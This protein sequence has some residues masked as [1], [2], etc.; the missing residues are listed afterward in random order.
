S[1]DDFTADWHETLTVCAICRGLSHRAALARLLYAGPWLADPKKGQAVNDKLFR[2]GAAVVLANSAVNLPHG[3]AHVGE[4]AYLPPLANAFVT[5]VIVLAPF[6]AL[7][8]LRAGRLR[9]G[10]WLLFGSMLGALLFGVVYH[11]VL[12][13]PD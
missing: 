2:Y 7:G 3:A 10:A 11:F 1:L 4:S 6:V 8:L 9:A 5:L 13:G 12:P